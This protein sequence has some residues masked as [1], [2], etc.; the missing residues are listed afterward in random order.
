[1]RD[2]QTEIERQTEK[3]AETDGQTDRQT[4]LDIHRKAGWMDGQR[5]INTNKQIQKEFSVKSNERHQP[6]L[7]NF[8]YYILP[9][10]LVLSFNKY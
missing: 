5:Q 7:D 2:R 3:E 10:G 6:T 9:A 1:M 4:D 8:K